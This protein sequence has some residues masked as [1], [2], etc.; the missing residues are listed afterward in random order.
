MYEFL[1]EEKTRYVMPD[2]NHGSDFMKTVKT[3]PF[4]DEAR[5]NYTE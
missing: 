3:L 2:N 5:A 1:K 4:L